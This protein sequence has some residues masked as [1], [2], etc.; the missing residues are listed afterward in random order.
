MRCPACG[1]E[2]SEMKVED[3]IVDVCEGGCGGIWFDQFELAKVDEK[4]E[5][6]GERLLSIEK[7]RGISF[8]HSKRRMCPRCEDT[9]LMR[10][11]FSVKQQV[12][13]DECPSCG[14]FWL[15]QGELGMIRSQYATERER[16][17][18]AEKYFSAL[19]EGEMASMKREG[20]EKMKKAE[21]IAQV[22][23][24]LCPSYYL[25]GKQD[26]GAF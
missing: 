18:A 4:H 12:E 25:K 2:L 26:W 11:F 20:A 16:R 24:F 19:F 1:R 6:A 14:G 7:A 17:E 3:I 9:V 23:R 13:V 5:S 21:K 22:L 8:D 15:D 10:H